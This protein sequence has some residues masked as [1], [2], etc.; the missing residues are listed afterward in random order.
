MAGCGAALGLLAT[1]GVLQGGWGFGAVHA[2][3][4]TAW[5]RNGTPEIDP[6]ARAAMA[7][8]GDIPLG[9]AE[10][11]ELAARRD[12]GGDW[13]EGRCDYVFEGRIPV[14]RFWT[15]TLADPEGALIANPLQR[16]GIT[17][18][19]VLRGEDGSFSVAIAA[20]ARPGNWLPV[21]H[22][23]RF[24]AILRLYDTVISATAAALDARSLPSIAKAGCR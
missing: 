4:W 24:M 22:R 6:Y 9:L 16:F 21:G 14:S 18:S 5:P 19:E 20:Q 17:S 15:L 23:K 11:V 10:G 12:Y 3:I 7:R 8:T 2:G 13:L 1:Y